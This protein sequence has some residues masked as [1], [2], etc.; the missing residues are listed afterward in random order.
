MALL[1][2]QQ[3]KKL[4]PNGDYQAYL[5]YVAK[6]R[7]ISVAQLKQSAQF[8][9]SAQKLAQLTAGGGGTSGPRSGGKPGVKGQG[10]IPPELRRKMEQGLRRALRGTPLGK[11][12]NLFMVAAEVSG[13]DARFLAGLAALESAW[14]RSTPGNAPFN[15]W[16][17]SVNTGQ[18]HSSIASPFQAADTAFRYF[19][20]SFGRKYK[21]SNL[22]RDFSPYAADPAWESKVASIVRR[23]GGNPYDVR[24]APAM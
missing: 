7:N 1:T 6:R 5:G 9:V 18:Q 3:F 20:K 8:G 22:F 24:F 17:W 13:F 23:M 11:Y 4:R 14:G 16:G 2:K 21:G 12:V 15:F 19:G 10:R